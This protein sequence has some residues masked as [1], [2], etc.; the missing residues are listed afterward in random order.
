MR[1]R[2]S[3]PS[4]RGSLIAPG[5]IHVAIGIPAPRAEAPFDSGRSW[6]FGTR[7]E[8]RGRSRPRR[9]STRRLPAILVLLGAGAGAGLAVAG[10]MASL[11]FVLLT[12]QPWLLGA[13]AIDV[14]IPVVALK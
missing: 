13:V 9:C 6:L 1:I 5:L 4:P 12:F 3:L 10:A 7:A 14:V 11:R 8:S 2:S